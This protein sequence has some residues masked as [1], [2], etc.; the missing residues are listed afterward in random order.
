MPATGLGGCPF[1]DGH[2]AAGHPP[3]CHQGARP[4]RSAPRRWPRSP[5]SSICSPRRCRRL[6]FRLAL[7]GHSLVPAAGPATAGRLRKAADLPARRLSAGRGAHGCGLLI[8]VILGSPLPIAW[9]PSDTHW[10][11]PE[12]TQ[13]SLPV[14]GQPL[15]GRIRTYRVYD[16]E[17]QA[18]TSSFL[19]SQAWPG[20]RHIAVPVLRSRKMLGWVMLYRNFD[21]AWPLRSPRDMPLS[22]T[23][24]TW[25]FCSLVPLTIQ[26]QRVY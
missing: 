17:F 8:A 10:G 7:I 24:L 3:S 18:S 6:T 14:G 13:D 2:R 16:E 21:P 11:H 9:H 22:G 19:P 25:R 4:S 23:R 26:N 5:R 1:R 12:A 20:A 15:P